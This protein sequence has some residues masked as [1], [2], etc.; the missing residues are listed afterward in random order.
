M[1]PVVHY[2]G[3]VAR[4]YWQRSRGRRLARGAIAGIVV[5]C[6]VFLV[7]ALLCC[8]LCCCRKK[9]HAKKASRHG[10][11]APASGGGGLLGRFWGGRYRG[12]HPGM[13]EAGFG[14]GYDAQAPRPAYR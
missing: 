8:Y 1:D 4:Q 12:T 13:S 5:G 9:R 7:A 2:A 3:L 10:H 6:V 14:E 11:T